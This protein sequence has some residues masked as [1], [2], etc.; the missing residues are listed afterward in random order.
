M[1]RVV[2]LRLPEE[3][4]ERL[5]RTARRAGRS[6]NEMGARSIE[7]WLRQS[8]LADIEFRTFS[9]QRH[10]CIK[11][12]LPVW[13]LIMVARHYGMDVQKTAAHFE[14]PPR[15]VQAGFTY[16]Q[17]YPAEIDQAIADNQS[18][19]AEQLRRVLPGLEIIT[20]RAKPAR[21]RRPS[22]RHAF[23]PAR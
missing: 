11:G 14:W 9:G 21:R 3:T 20:T 23:L 2:S 17:A 19:S 7:E 5:K 10:A 22:R 4:A 1:S 15:K 12:A 8:E 13:Q 18:M 6:V 16:Y